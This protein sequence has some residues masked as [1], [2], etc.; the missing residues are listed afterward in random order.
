MTVR[1][2]KR[3]SPTLE[4][5]GTRTPRGASLDISR[6]LA[7]L[8]EPQYSM[9]VSMPLAAGSSSRVLQGCAPRGADLRQDGRE[10]WE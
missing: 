6:P 10:M 3:A 2:E 9:V 7:L 4:P 1:Q 5:G 8:P